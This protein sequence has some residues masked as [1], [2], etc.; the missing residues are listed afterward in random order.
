M[1]WQRGD[2]AIVCTDMDSGRESAVVSSASGVELVS[3]EGSLVAWTTRQQGVA[4]VGDA[5]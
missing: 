5:A 3:V 1:F 2:D 4:N